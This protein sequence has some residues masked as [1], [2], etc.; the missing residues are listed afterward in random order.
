MKKV[1][2]VKVLDK[3]M[4]E[5]GK[6]QVSGKPAGKGGIVKQGL[7]DTASPLPM[8]GEQAPVQAPAPDGITPDQA[9]A[10]KEPI[11]EVS[12]ALPEAP[13]PQE[14]MPNLQMPAE[15]TAIPQGVQQKAAAPN[16]QQVVDENGYDPRAHNGSFRFNVVT[17]TKGYKAGE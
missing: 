8:G 11:A 17:G 13:I 14:A 1:R 12:G 10:I 7:L 3:D 5:L 16:L 15:N 9:A 2:E 6:E 4:K